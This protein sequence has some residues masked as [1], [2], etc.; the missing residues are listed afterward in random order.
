M[1]VQQ[2]GSSH[3]DAKALTTL[4]FLQHARI[5]LLLELGVTGRQVDEV[6]AMRQDLVRQEAKVQACRLEG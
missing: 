3:L 6:G 1:E 2:T 5:A 4:Q